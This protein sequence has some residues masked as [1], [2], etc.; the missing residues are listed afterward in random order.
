MRRA[1]S[2]RSQALLARLGLVLVLLFAQHGALLHAYSHFGIVPDP[3]A[4]PG[5]HSPPA[6]GCDMGVVH[7]ALD[8]DPPSWAGLLVAE[9]A[10]PVVGHRAFTPFHPLSLVHFHSRAPPAR[11]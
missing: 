11:T 8:G 10:P 7:A 3:Y 6:Q 9:F 1:Y 2:P 4:T 5:S